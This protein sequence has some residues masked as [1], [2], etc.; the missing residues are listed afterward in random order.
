LPPSPPASRLLLVSIVL[1][2]AVSSPSIAQ[3]R[4]EELVAEPG[5]AEQE[6][7]R[8]A[9]G[10]RFRV[11]TTKHF[12]VISDTSIRYHTVVAGLLEQFYQLVHPRFFIADMKPVRFYL[13][14]GGNDYERFMRERGLP[15]ASGYGLYESS[16]RTL[17]ARR[18]FPD[19]RE[20][21]VGTLFH[22]AV[23]AMIDADFAS[24]LPPRWVNEGF[25]SLFEVGRVIRGQ[26]V[27]GNPNPWRE[28]PFRAAYEQGDVPSLSALLTTP[29]AAFDGTKARCDILYNAGRSLFLFVLRSHG[30]RA[31]A[32]YVH[33]LRQG[34]E[35]AKALSAATGLELPEIEQGWH[36]SIRQLNFGGDYLNRGNGLG[37][38]A[39]LEEGARLHPGYGNLQV[40]LA[41]EYLNREQQSKALMHARRALEDPHLIFRQLAQ[42]AVARAI[43][44][45]DANAAARA[46]MASLSH[47]PWNEQIVGDDYEMLSFMFDE[48]GDPARAKRVRSDLEA[49]RRLDIR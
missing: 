11:L 1:L 31:L 4:P 41:I 26:W 18:Y 20:S 17:Y 14:N 3:T 29:D 16:S 23:H 8:A 38:V 15:N 27:Y 21:G 33:R 39:V 6:K 5:H 19:G 46:L 44:S 42:F 36:A 37:G 43:L 30:E 49:I 45:T 2:F 40:T 47:Q 25:A 35:P 12:H 32:A 48:A 10:D 22:E 9:Y 28:T 13:I 34:I 24:S 7:A